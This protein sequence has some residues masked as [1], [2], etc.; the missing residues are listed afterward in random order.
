MI[1]IEIKASRCYEVLVAAGLSDSLGTLLK[2]RIGG[3]KLLLV[4]DETVFSLY[5]RQITEV[6]ENKGYVVRNFI[7]PVGE[8]S[9]SIGKYCELVEMMANWQMTRSDI[10]LALGGG[11]IG[12]LTGFAAASYLRGIRFVQ[13]PTTVLAMVDSSVGGKTAVNLTIGKN[14]MG[15][16]YQPHLVVVDPSLLR[17]L[18]KSVMIDGCAEI[19]KYA[20]LDKP[21]L[22]EAVR[23]CFGEGYQAEKQAAVCELIADC[24][25]IKQ[26]FVVDD[27]FDTGSRQQLNL[28]HT[29]GHAI[30]SCSN[31]A[32]SH[33]RAV[34]IGMN[35]MT[36]IA[37][38]AGICEPSVLP[39]LQRVCR[40]LGLPT[41]T[42]FRADEL[43]PYLLSDKKRGDTGITVV[44]P[45]RLGRCILQT[46]TIEEFERLLREELA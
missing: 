27:E 39:T 5:G 20:L 37:G 31:F 15:V 1:Q 46:L 12:D 35:L 18:P 2:E 25:R 36:G 23:H 24:I 4:S 41:E 28:G 6:L 26:R 45:S 10:A 34:A 17:T 38:R 44:W 16:F 13:L 33:G 43:L 32:V 19:L 22:L 3:E 14:L 7:V 9:K 11:V 30:E 8:T 29:I 21:T 42:C 40:Q